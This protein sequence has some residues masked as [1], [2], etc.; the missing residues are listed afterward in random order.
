MIALLL[1]SPWLKALF[2]PARYD[3][4]TPGGCLLCN[5]AQ[6][7]ENQAAAIRLLSLIALDVIGRKP[8]W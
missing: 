3:C 8:P 2:N 1:F 7:D 4:L 6:M 5:I